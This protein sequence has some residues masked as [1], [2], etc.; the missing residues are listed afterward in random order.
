MPTLAVAKDSLFSLLGKSYTKDEF[1]DLCFEF[2]IELDDVTSERE[3]YRREHEAQATTKKQKE[4]LKKKLDTLS[5]I[6]M[7][8]IDTPANRYD[9]LCAEGMAIALRVFRGLMPAPKFTM[10]PPKLTMTVKK[11]TRNVRDF[12]V[13]AVLRNLKFNEQSYRSFI[14]YQDKLHSGLAR[15]RTLASVGT[16]DLDKLSGTNFTYECRPRDQIVFVPLNQTQTLNCAEDGLVKFYANDRHI[17]KFVPYIADFPTYPVIL[18]QDG[19]VLSLPPII[20]SEKSKIDVNT[21]NMFIECTAPDLHK[22]TV[23]VEQLVCSFSMYCENPF[24]VERVKVVYEDPTAL[25]E[26]LKMKSAGR[27]MEHW[28]N[29]EEEM[30]VDLQTD[31]E[32][33]P[34]MYHKKVQIC[35]ADASRRVGINVDAPKAAELLQKMQLHASPLL[36]A[37]GKS[38]SLISVSIPPCRSDVLHPCDIIEDVAIAYGYDNIVYQ[39]TPTRSNGFQQPLNKLTHLLR[40]EAACAGFTEMLT[41]SLCSRDEAFANLGRK[42]TDV[43]VHIANPQTVEFQICRPSLLPGSLKVFQANKSAPLPQKFFECTDIVLLDKSDRTGCRNERHFAAL[44]ANAL[45]SESTGYEDI[46]GLAEQMLSK[47]GLHKKA[48]FEKFEELAAGG[49]KGVYTIE[50]DEGEDA[51]NAFF[52]GRRVKLMVTDISDIAAATKNNFPRVRVGGFGVLHPLVLKSIEM[53]VPASYCEFDI[54]K[55][56]KYSA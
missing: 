11:S 34:D 26:S 20:N 41:F 42:D 47:L 49:V 18:D 39:E 56:L 15:K 46:Q 24:E 51:D 25:R 33:T 43:A 53:Q 30:H 8:K 32:L 10:L 45:S 28:T 14:D 22:A 36:S 17:S 19:S 23:L 31:H 3:M 55:L 35:A 44:Q 7:Y 5:A 40:A 50:A 6:E 27:R 21:K 12:V 29:T 9:L 2:G 38:S 37:E 16:H 13:C 48:H 54:T 4:D 52:P 1:E